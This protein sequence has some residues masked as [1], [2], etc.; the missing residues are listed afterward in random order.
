MGIAEW[1]RDMNWFA[2]LLRRVQCWRDFAARVERA[3][4]RE[5]WKQRRERVRQER[6]R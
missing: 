5:A 3:R 4:R 1:K 2:K 6:A